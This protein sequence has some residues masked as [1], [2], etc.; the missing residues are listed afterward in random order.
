MITKG[1]KITLKGVEWTVLF[2]DA[3]RNN[4]R[5]TVK[6]DKGEGVRDVPLDMILNEKEKAME[7]EFKI[8]CNLTGN[9]IHTGTY[10]SCKEK[11]DKMHN[12]RILTPE[13]GEGL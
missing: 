7:N 6:T 13:Q 1:D 10:E 2:V 8:I 9:I 11:A 4:C 3:V 12:V 5:L